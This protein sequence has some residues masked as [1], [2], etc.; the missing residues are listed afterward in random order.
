MRF[1][2]LLRAIV[3]DR[4]TALLV[5][6]GLLAVAC[7]TIP[8]DAITAD[9]R[10]VV[11]T[12]TITDEPDAETTPLTPTTK[13]NVETTPLTPTTKDNVETTLPAGSFDLN[14]R[15][16]VHVGTAFEVRPEVRLG[17][18]VTVWLESDH[19]APNGDGR[20]VALTMGA[21]TFVGVQESTD[22]Y[23][24]GQGSTTVRV[25]RRPAGLELEVPNRVR[26]DE[27]FNVETRSESDG[28]ITLSVSGGCDST[29]DD[30][31][32][33]PVAAELCVFDVVQEPT[34]SHDRGKN[35]ARVVVDK[36]IPKIGVDGPPEELMH[37]QSFEVVA[38]PEAGG[39][40]T[41]GD[42]EGACSAPGPQDENPG[43]AA[44]VGAMIR[45]FD[46]E[47]TGECSIEITQEETDRYASGT[48]TETYPVGLPFGVVT[49]KAVTVLTWFPYARYGNEN[50]FD[51]TVDVV[52]GSR[53]LVLVLEGDCSLVE[54]SP[55]IPGTFTARA[56]G[57]GQCL[58]KVTQGPSSTHR[59]DPQTTHTVTINKARGSFELSVPSLVEVN[60]IVG[61]AV[62]YVSGGAVTVSLVDGP[63]TQIDDRTFSADAVG[64]C[65]IAATQAEHDQY[66]P[67]APVDRQVTIDDKPP[68]VFDVVSP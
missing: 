65:T 35:R 17:G 27:V 21:C 41:I 40:V 12:P 30:H 2:G 59:P 16:I 57:P 54:V 15:E 6:C 9:A 4:L 20:W 28:A 56:S 39:P 66:T 62:R 64:I 11:A 29:A 32:F 34:I 42:G 25:D 37:P 43:S 26:I 19:C 22:R 45:G 61:V 7:G 44:P 51:V 63:C 53:D 47:G 46:T 55:I 18:P 48:S 14:A 31:Q 67:H 3:K 36:L 38:W 10:P 1:T 24:P 50:D 60:D 23:R 58:I 49:I 33:L 5:G 8:D 13:D 68:V 52:S